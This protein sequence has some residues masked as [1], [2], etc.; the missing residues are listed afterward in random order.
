MYARSAS[1]PRR[2][3]LNNKYPPPFHHLSF[4]TLLLSLL[5]YKMS[6]HKRYVLFLAFQKSSFHLAMPV[7]HPLLSKFESGRGW[8]KACTS[9]YSP[10][11]CEAP[12]PFISLDSLQYPLELSKPKIV[13]KTW[14]VRILGVPEA[15]GH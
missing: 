1:L 7:P 5:D 14:Y 8:R 15:I 6:T 3:I 12:L 10:G 13:N 11:E 4:S 2:S 9:T